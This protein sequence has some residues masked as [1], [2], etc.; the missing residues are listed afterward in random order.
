MVP[1]FPR[2]Y[3][4]PEYSISRIIKGGWQ[5]AGGHGLIEE[6]KAIKDMFSFAD[7]FASLFSSF[8]NMSASFFAF[9]IFFAMAI[10]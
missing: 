6:Q 2:S 7:L 5:L 1:N 10:G 8:E 9:F 4:Q 3:L